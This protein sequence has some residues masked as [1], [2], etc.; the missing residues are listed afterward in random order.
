ME[1]DDRLE[2][3]LARLRP[4]QVK[5]VQART[6]S[7]DLAE[8]VVQQALLR[9]LEKLHSLRQP[10]RLPAWFRRIVKHSLMDE[11]ARRQKQLPL[12]DWLARTEADEPPAAEAESAACLCSL[13]LLKQ[14][15]PAYAELL[16]QVDLQD[17]PLQEAAA[18]LGITPNN[19]GV[20]LHR[21]RQ[22]LRR[23]LSE[24]CG[25]DSVA[26]CRDCG[27]DAACCG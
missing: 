18:A 8:E 26:A 21:A 14:L 20:R 25:T 5:W 17:Q 16:D 6:G 10:E 24:T 12:E 13:E 1:S 27:C 9:A 11:L 15:K 23:K 4:A 2:L 3:A 7:A 22:A 19:A